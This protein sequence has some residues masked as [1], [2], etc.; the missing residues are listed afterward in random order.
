MK[1]TIK[2]VR[3]H[4]I[5]STSGYPTIETTVALEDG[6]TAVVSVPYGTSAGV[7]E[8]VTLVDGDPKRY[9]GK[10]MLKAVDNV[11]K[12]I[13][14]RV[15][16]ADAGDQRSIDNLL[17]SLDPSPQRANLGGN[18]ILSVSLA[19]ARAS[20]NS[21][22]VPLYQHIRQTYGLPHK[23]YHLPKPM[24]VVIEGGQHADNSTDFQEYLVGV[25]ADQGARKNVQIGIEVYLTLGKLLKQKGYSTN[26]GTEGAFAPTAIKSNEEPLMYIEKAISEAGYKPGKDAAIA[27]DPAA[28]EFYSEDGMY[29]LE[30]DGRVLSSQDMISLYQDLVS[31][32]PIFSL[33]DGLSEDDWDAW[34][35]LNATLGSK[36]IVMGDDLTVTNVERLKRAID[37]VAINAVLIKPNQ[38]GTLSETIDAICLAQ[39]NGL[40][41]VVSH[42]GGGETT[43]T[44]II[45]LAVATNSE[46]VKVGPTRG[47]RVVK[48]NRLMEIADELGK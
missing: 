2:L 20:A 31:R 22:Q 21:K 30:R 1:T 48:Y 17:I 10:G 47:E 29:H 37:L 6:T 25:I 5:L 35:S 18:S 8:A 11:N 13:A 40:R 46:F 7:H 23:D 26:V 38:C 16:G 12:V 33:E 24:M 3:A 45:D 43:D 44:F 27:L 4:E 28:S 41:T 36:I 14:P 19:C 39:K 34:P 32:Y 9:K 42:R 15:I